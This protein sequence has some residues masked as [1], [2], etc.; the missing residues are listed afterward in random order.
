LEPE[1]QLKNVEIRI[2]ILVI[3]VIFF[4]IVSLLYVGYKKDLFAR[5]ISYTVISDTGKKLFAGMPV[6]FEGFAMGKVSKIE[7]NDEGKIVLTLKI[8]EKYQKWIK[9]D[10][11]VFFNQESVIGNPYLRFTAGSKDKE[12]MPE[13]SVF[14]LEYEGGIDELIKKAEPVVEDLGQIVWNVRLVSDEFTDPEGSLMRFLSSMESI[15]YKMDR[16]KGIMP[17]IINNEEGTAKIGRIMD[18]LIDLEQSIDRLTINLDESVNNRLN[19]ILDEVSKA[20]KDLYLLRRKGEYTL[21]LS[22]DLLFK[23]NNTWPL[24]PGDKKRKSPELPLP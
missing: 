4:T 17:Y 6:K 1:R 9:S 18:K 15:G 5:R 23:L 3:F 14:T 19:P 24:S 16:G 7:L 12:V 21:D 20:T 2:G 8:L 22:K 10:S 13:N 11:R